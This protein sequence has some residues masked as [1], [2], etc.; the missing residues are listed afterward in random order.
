M[1]QA[2]IPDAG[3]AINCNRSISPTYWSPA[4]GSCDVENGHYY[5]NNAVFALAKASG[6]LP[7]RMAFIAYNIAISAQAAQEFASVFQQ[8]GGTVCYS[9]YSVSP[10]TASMAADV[11]QM[12]ADNCGGVF[13]TVDVTG[14]AK[15][16]QAMAQQSFHPGYVGTTFDGYTPSQIT[17]AGQAAAQGLIVDLPFIPLNESQ[18]AVQLYQQEL[19]SYEPGKQPSGFGFLAWESSQMLLYA[20]IAGGHSPTRAGVVRTFGS[21]RSWTGGGALGPFDASNKKGPGCA[22][23]VAVQGGQ[24]VRKAPASGL[25]CGGSWFDVGAAS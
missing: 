5:V 12:E 1:A 22:V 13:T 9:D 15:L 7:S 2:G 10:A 6:Y 21:L 8:M 25:F 23:D 16:L 14:N 19:A 3:F 4:G 18:S 17:A 11:Q 20:L 24:F